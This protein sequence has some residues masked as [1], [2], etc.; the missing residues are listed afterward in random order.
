MEKQFTIPPLR[1]ATTMKK[2][3]EPG[4]FG[5]LD[6]MRVGLVNQRSEITTK[7]PLEQS[8][9][10][11]ELNQHR[12]KLGMSNSISGSALPMTIQAERAS[13]ARIGRLPGVA[14][15]YLHLE[16]FAGMD[17]DLAIEDLFDGPSPWEDSPQHSRCNATA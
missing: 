15:S 9:L 5:V 12:I 7:H 1:P 3:P 17:E 10:F 11:Y 4:P 16:V 13:A 14:S 6:T 2:A 8:E